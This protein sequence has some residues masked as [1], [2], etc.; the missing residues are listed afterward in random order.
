MKTWFYYPVCSC[1]SWVVVLSC[2]SVV[3]RPQITADFRIRI[4]NGSLIVYPGKRNFPNARDFICYMILVTFTWCWW[5]YDGDSFK[6]LMVES[7]CWWLF[8]VKIGHQLLV[9]HPQSCH[10]HKPSPTFV[11]NFDQAKVSKI[12][13]WKALI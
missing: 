2:K 11:T 1:T 3:K 10:Q 7:L 8:D 4:R 5:L 12:F 6:K 13:W 9:G